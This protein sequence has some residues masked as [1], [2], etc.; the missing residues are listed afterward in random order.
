M[1][2]YCKRMPDGSPLYL[3][4][5][6]DD[7]LLIGPNEDDIETTKRKIGE[8]FI[9]RGGG[10][11]KRFIG[12]DF[13]EIEGGLRLNQAFADYV[14]EWLAEKYRSMVAPCCTLQGR[15]DLYSTSLIP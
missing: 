15:R 14:D 10:K 1:T 6:I 8:F 2:I 5:Y 13:I 11:L 9:C 4:A 3:G 7:L 12:I